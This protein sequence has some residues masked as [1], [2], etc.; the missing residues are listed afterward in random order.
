MNAPF[1]SV[2]WI[3]RKVP[4]SLISHGAN[5]LASLLLG[6]AQVPRGIALVDEIESGLYHT[7]FE[8]MWT[9]VAS[10]AEAYQAQLFATT[11]SQECLEAAV[12]GLK[13]DNFT[14]IQTS[15]SN[16]DLTAALVDGAD[17]ALAIKHGLEVRGRD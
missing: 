1:V 2:P 11:H 4:L 14:L 13:P 7:R 16:G 3:P 8:K 12:K 6:I 10:V 5:F 9:Q 15:R 17:A